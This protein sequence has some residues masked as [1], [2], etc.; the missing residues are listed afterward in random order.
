[1]VNGIFRR[2]DLLREIVHKGIKYVVKFLNSLI[3]PSFEMIKL[4]IK[5]NIIFVFQKY[6]CEEISKSFPSGNRFGWDIS[7]PFLSLPCKR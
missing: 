6:F 4:V 7:I 1:M 5:G 2:L 3:W